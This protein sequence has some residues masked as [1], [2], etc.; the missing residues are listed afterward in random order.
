MSETPQSKHEERPTTGLLRAVA[1]VGR[2]ILG[3]LL[4]RLELFALELSEVRNNALRLLLVAALG[5]MAVWFA[6]AY[7]SVLIVVLTWEALGWK[8][9][10]G[11]AL[12]FTALAYALFRYVIRL[13]ADGGLSLPATMQELRND[14]DALL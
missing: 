3:L 8:V 9:L 14:R 6:V 4:N 13:V 2:N 12:L 1:E 10:L 5:L 11:F 7:W